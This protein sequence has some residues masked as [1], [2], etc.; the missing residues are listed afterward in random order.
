[1]NGS[2]TRTRRIS[3]L[4]RLRAVGAAVVFA[5]A[6]FAVDA[7]PVALPGPLGEALGPEPALAGYCASGPNFTGRL[8]A[9]SGSTTAIA[10]T[11]SPTVFGYI[12]N[13]AATW[14]CTAY[15]RYS[16]ITWNTAAT[17][18]SFQWGNLINS[19]SV[20]CNF[21]VGST[22]YI[23]GNSTSDCPDSDA[24]YALSATLDAER[25]YQRDLAHNSIGDFSY[26]QSDCASYYGQKPLKTGQTFETTGTTGNRPDPNNCDPI[27]LDDTATT[28]T[29]TYDHTAPALDFTTP[30]E[31]T[32][33]YRNAANPFNVIDVI[34]EAVAGFAAPNDWELQ[35]QIASIISPNVCGTFANDAATGNLTTGVST[36]SITTPQNLVNGKCYR[37]LL[38][39]TDQNGN[40]ATTRTSG[41]VLYDTTLPATDF[42]TPDEGTTTNQNTAP[43]TV[44]W[45]EAD[46]ASGV[47]ARS[48]QRRKAAWTTGSCSGLTFAD[49]P[50]GSPV[51]TVSP[52]AATL[53]TGN[54]YYWVQTLTDRAGNSSAANSGYVT[55][56][57]SPTADFSAPNEGTCAYQTTTSYGVNWGESAGSG[58]IT[59]R[60][61]QRQKATIVTAGGCIGL[62][63]SNDGTAVTNAS[64][65]TSSSMVNG[66]C[67]RWVQTLTNS[68]PKTGV[69]TSGT[70]C[71][72]TIAPVG[73]ITFPDAN[74]P[75]AGDVVVTGTAVDAS[76]FYNYQLDYGVGVSPGSWTTIGTFTTQVLTT[77]PLA[78]W[79]TGTLNGVYSLRLIV[80]ESAGGANSVTTRVVYLEN[81]ERGEEAYQSRVPFD[82]GGGWGLDVGVSN[83][84]AR[85]SRDLFSI[86][87]FGTPQE[88]GLSYS[89][90]ETG[91]AG[92]FGVGW[93][94]NL[95]QYLTFENGFVV[96]HRADGGRVPFG[97]IAGVW[98]P[99]RGH[100]EV[101]G[102]GTGTYI[103][104]LKDQ[105]K[106]T[107][108][109]TGLGR[110]TKIENRFAKALTL[111][112][113]TSSAT[114]T[115]ASGRLTTLAIDSANNRITAATDSANRVWGFG[116]TGTDL[117]TVTD[118]A[119]KLTTLGYDASHHLTSV[120][121]TRS[122]VVGGLE[123]ITWGVGYTSGTA[124][125]VTDPVNTSVSN[126]FTYDPGS[127]VVAIL[128]EYSPVT[129]NTTSYTYDSL[130]RVVSLDDPAAFTSTW[131]YDA[132]SNVLTAGRE[133]ID[134]SPAVATSTYDARGNKLT[135]AT[136]IDA[137]TTVT[138]LMTYNAINDLLIVSEADNDPATKRITKNT[139]DG[140]GHLTSVDVNCTTSG[141]TPPTTASTCTGAGTQDSATNLITNN[142]YTT[143]D[144]LAYEQDPLG[145]VTKHVYDAWGNET[146]TIANCTTTGT[147]APSPFNSCTAAGTHDVQTN[148]TSTYAFDQLT[149]AGKAGL[150]TS[151]T[152]PVGNTTTSTYD[153][154]GRQLT[155]VFPGDTTIPADTRTT[156]YDELGNTLTS[157][158]A[159]TPLGGGS[160]VSRST[161]H[162]YDLANRETAAT[163]P[164]GIVTTT[165]YD[166]SGDPV[167][168]S[169]SA[170]ETTVSYSGLRLPTTIIR[171]GTVDTERTYD[172]FGN[173]L[174][175]DPA[176]GVSVTRTF[177]YTGLER[178][179]TIPSPTGDI[180]TTHVY[181]PLG[182]ELSIA[183]PAGTTINTYDRAGRLK[184][185]TKAAGVTTYTYDRAGNQVSVLDPAGIVTTTTF[186]PLDRATVTVAN[187][188]ATPTLPSQDVTTK[189]W[190]NAAGTPV[191]ATDAKGVSSRSIPN[192]RGFAAQAIANCT[193]SGTT[194]TSNPPACVGAGTQNSTTNVKTTATFDGTGAAILST[195]AV[196]TGAQAATETA[197]DAAGH[198]QAVKDPRGT[199]SRTFY[200]PTS[201]Q[202]TKTVVN[203]TT[204][205]TTIPTDWPNCTGAGTADGTF[206]LTTTYAYDARGRRTT[207]TAPNL[208]VTTT[209]FDGADRVIQTIANDVTCG[210]PDPP[211]APT[212]DLT[213][214]IVYD[215]AGRQSAVVLPTA[216]GASLAVTRFVY[217]TAG[218]MTRQIENCT[219]ELETPPADPGACSGAGT[220]DAD[221]NVAIDSAYDTKGNRVKAIAPSPAATSGTQATLVTTRFAYDVSNRLCRVVENSTQDDATWAGLADQCSTAI[222]GT[223]TTNASTRYTYDGVGNLASMVDPN[224]HTTTYTYDAAGRMT[225]LGDALG[226]STAW[227][228][229]DLGEQVSQT[230]RSDLTALTPTIAWTYDGAGRQLTRTVETAAARDSLAPAV[231]SG[232]SAVAIIATRVDLAWTAAADDVGV[233]KYTIRRNGAVLTQVSAASTAFSDVSVAGSSAYSYT[234]DASD[235]A[236]NA[237]AQS[238]A[239]VAT[240]PAG[241]VTVTTM[242]T[243]ADTYVDGT[244][245]GTKG[246]NYGTSSLLYVDGNRR[247][248][249]KFDAS[250]I[251]PGTVSL[252]RLSIKTN[253]SQI[254]G[255][256]SVRRSSTTSW[257]ETG[258]TWNN[259][260]AY[261]AT[262][263][264]TI[265]TNTSDTRTYLVV[266][267]TVTG[268]GVYAFVLVT[269]G[270]TSAEYK[271]KES[272]AGYEA[273]LEVTTPTSDLVAPTTPSGLSAMPV[274]PDAVSLVWTASTDAVG[275]QGYKIYRGGVYQTTVGSTSWTDTGLASSTAYTYTIAAVD[276]AGNT[277]AQSTSSAA[278]TAPATVTTT[279][280]Y[281]A[282]GNKL[283]ASDGTLTIAA[284]YDRV[285]RPLTV[286]DE[287]A[288]TTADTTYAYSL[289]APSWTDPTG[290]YLVT[291]DRFDRPT[292]VDGP[293]TA[294][295]TTA[296]R[297]DGQPASIVAPNGNTTN[298]AYDTLGRETGRSTAAVGPVNRA[299]YALA[300]NRAGQILSET[301]TITGDPTN[302]ATTYAYDPLERL[303]SFTRAASS[304]SYAWQAFPNRASV[305]VGAG[306]PVTTTYDAANRPTSDSAGGTYASDADGRLRT[307]PG[308]RLGWD[309]LGRLVS[310]RPPTGVATTATYTYDP[311]DRLRT[312]DHGAG[313]RTRFR[314]VGLTTSVAQT[315]DDLTGSII[316]AVGTG[317][318]G[319]AMVDWTG[320]GA[321]LRFYGTNAHHD[322]TW[323]ASSS[324]TVSATL[325]YDPWGTVTASTGSSLPDVRFQG[326]WFDPTTDLAWVISRWYAPSLGRFISEDSLLGDQSDPP[327]RHLYAY[328]AG[329]P[330]GRWDPDGRLWWK[331]VGI[332]F[333]T[334]WPAGNVVR[335]QANHLRLRIS[336]GIGIGNFDVSQWGSLRSSSVLY[337]GPTG[338][339]A[340]PRTISAF[341]HAA[342]LSWSGS[343]NTPFG[344]GSMRF[345]AHHRLVDQTAGRTVSH[346]VTIVTAKCG[347]A[348]WPIGAS[349]CTPFGDN[350]S[351]DRVNLSI[352]SSWAVIH[353]HRYVVTYLALIRATVGPSYFSV[354]MAH[355]A[356]DFSGS[357]AWWQ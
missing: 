207:E 287:D 65:Y 46:T 276:G 228:Y 354:S 193:D 74:R 183:E 333:A 312:A 255:I 50:P 168:L 289:A 123:T 327:N 195:T 113:N 355:D 296:Y 281:D 101:L 200:D 117:T 104:T 43:Y 349:I 63:W 1:M 94:S 72:D 345:E 330:I 306:T 175:T 196:G 140:S 157:T 36:G 132:D 304:N 20:A 56:D 274:G 303:T 170:V 42:T 269:T 31:S 73:A 128:K 225:G 176:D 227:A 351:G 209:A 141:T 220:A 260:P 61:L 352:K 278:T 17:T 308:Q 137:S 185:M 250:T 343:E 341:V 145:R 325:R 285:N 107:F 7:A 138:T 173:E 5:V 336:S 114:A 148:V 99:L 147:A 197:Y 236:A 302:G 237:S 41:T 206:N 212:E 198:S 324:G 162:A 59:A 290:T 33:T 55:Y 288:G 105:T 37:W 192:V 214:T 300:Y 171:G 331:R 133:V 338:T 103:V 111:V 35:R 48:L 233:A 136:P 293:F 224:T 82:L 172:S 8:T 80:R 153:A 139:Y 319:E 93:V 245:G 257:T 243:I 130:G 91:T 248:W 144:Q 127:T 18:G 191:A 181:D 275:V 178:T 332:S 71:V 334:S 75:L 254:N 264:G 242:S 249:L 169:E 88:L 283:T 204:S 310:V 16:G 194:P 126:T 60:S 68:V 280:T 277:S 87:S 251:P 109:N 83:G 26:V 320:A 23:K 335:P 180:T 252:A 235:A 267:S 57:N 116:Y 96:W 353:N 10:R 49:D 151:S 150:A 344:L 298:F 256:S 346:V 272:L 270:T 15:F 339:V 261:D 156:T 154:L 110:L 190:Y 58:T 253:Q 108:E 89:S 21:V 328:G 223:A 266:T 81:A 67:Y 118:P 13:V 119:S 337:T 4:V 265:G 221:T 149:T 179:S 32:T 28:Q 329:E 271:A 44:A 98:T 19:N 39:A 347:G 210:T 131:S 202:P 112:W 322:T 323:T 238:T 167:D 217:D 85:L 187:D 2:L 97:S 273:Q 86:P 12:S 240:T 259:E 115:D 216:D 129:W 348:I 241:T 350:L 121:R 282:N 326:S 311:L 76:S 125:L 166:A 291:I 232:L 244:N 309:N 295:F 6:T 52:V 152:D 182:E 159:W 258:L 301:S 234:V 263:L 230:N 239:A 177:T 29:I 120:T 203:C 158:E 161:I 201:G 215:S 246:T 135:E 27:V 321:N 122:R 297:A 213:T 231:P 102:T 313:G 69:G 24:E 357:M 47:L 45:A 66:F 219:D 205:G 70:V 317:W 40:A 53:V 11:T 165:S 64:P 143:N 342:T 3:T 77:N 54:C 34:T 92:K 95:T 163:D 211:C 262:S 79:S 208:R 340:H 294:A 184:T 247:T 9:S 25:V 84:E 292:S 316:R 106:L 284:T 315:I 299:V 62:A 146:S 38:N 164:S 174:V 90:L 199:I 142:A 305:Q 186:D 30:N 22:D 226:Q 100:F 268:V 314:Y 124:T 134:A 188:V 356:L 318:T 222:S 160:G 286:D 279:Y 155:E 189:T 78:I 307:R 14:S 51:T 218:R 229:N